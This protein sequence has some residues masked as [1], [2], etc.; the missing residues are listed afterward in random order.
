MFIQSVIKRQ[1]S[2]Q[3]L[4]SVPDIGSE[5]CIDLEHHR[6]PVAARRMS[7]SSGPDRPTVRAA[8]AAVLPHPMHPRADRFGIA[9]DPFF[10]F[11]FLQYHHHFYIAIL[12][13]YTLGAKSVPVA[14]SCRM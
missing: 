11:C 10:Q 2:F 14:N 7:I 6:D 3:N 1:D 4:R 5:T 12:P 13:E 8:A 9:N